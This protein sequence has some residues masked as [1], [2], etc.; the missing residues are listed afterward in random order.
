MESSTLLFERT[1][2]Y[3]ATSK[4]KILKP[5]AYVRNT[6]RAIAF[7]CVY[8]KRDTRQYDYDNAK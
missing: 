3:I 8:L 7:E 5:I 6:V 4:F 1:S 2:T